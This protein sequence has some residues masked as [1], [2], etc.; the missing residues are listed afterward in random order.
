MVPVG[1]EFPVCS[2]ARSCVALRRSGF[3]RNGRP[4]GTTEVDVRA[5]ERPSERGEN[6]R[7]REM[8]AL[9]GV[10]HQSC[11]NQYLVEDI[12]TSSV[13]PAPI[14]VCV[15]SSRARSQ[16]GT[17]GWDLP[18]LVVPGGGLGHRGDLQRLR[19]KVCLFPRRLLG[20]LAQVRSDVPKLPPGLDFRPLRSRS[21]R[22]SLPPTPTQCP[23]RVRVH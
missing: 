1:D 7:E 18:D 9:R 16:S 11:T 5:T 2:R 20:T 6:E 15:V 23:C 22:R 17:S 3:R 8:E 19:P 10:R 14:R 4:G 13:T 12:G 21:R